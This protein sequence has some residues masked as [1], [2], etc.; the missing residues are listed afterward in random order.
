MLFN[1]L[2]KKAFTD[3]M[4]KIHIHPIYVSFLRGKLNCCPEPSLSLYELPKSPPALKCNQGPHMK[5]FIQFLFFFHLSFLTSL[6]NLT[7]SVCSMPVSPVT[8]TRCTGRPDDG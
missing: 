5:S 7:G 8:W 3:P 4:I 6:G 2:K 1:N